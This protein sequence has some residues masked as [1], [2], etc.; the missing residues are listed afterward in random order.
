MPGRK[1][2]R[3]GFARSQGLETALCKDIYV[4]FYL[5]SLGFTN[6]H[7]V[8]IFSIFT[9]VCVCASDVKPWL[10]ET[11]ACSYPAPWAN[12]TVPTP[13]KNGTDTVEQRPDKDFVGV[14]EHAAFGD[15][16]VY[17]EGDS[18]RYKFGRLMHGTLNASETKDTLYMNLDYPL[19]PEIFV[20]GYLRGFPVM[21]YES[22]GSNG[23]I[24][25]VK[26]PFLENDMYPVFK[27]S[28]DQEVK[29]NGDVRTHTGSSLVISLAVVITASYFH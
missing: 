8:C 14:Y 27:K 24:D 20:Y 13:P 25:E 7:I 12:A 17:L 3:F 19:E 5:G 26:V 11:T 22:D 4:L 6:I 29:T 16:T 10:D 9:K 2:K 21:F 18:L 1:C 15:F 28:R 23:K